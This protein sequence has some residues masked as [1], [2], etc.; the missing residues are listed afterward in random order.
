MDVFFPAGGRMWTAEQSM[1]GRWPTAVTIKLCLH[2]VF[3]LCL[4]SEQQ[5]AFRR[6]RCP[7]RFVCLFLSYQ[8]FPPLYQSASVITFTEHLSELTIDILRSRPPIEA[9]T[10]TT[11][12]RTFNHLCMKR[13]TT[14]N[15]AYL[16]TLH[17]IRLNIISTDVQSP[18][19][20][21]TDP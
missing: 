15:G 8:S 14:C 2:T 1:L 11:R 16:P 5:V 17:K 7:L 12:V 6:T 10:R 21:T 19:Y 4:R 20:Q 9:D 3:S 13:E 18:V